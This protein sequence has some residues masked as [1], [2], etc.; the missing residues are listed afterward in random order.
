MG[1]VSVA[2]AI[3]MGSQGAISRITLS[4]RTPS[5]WYRIIERLNLGE[6]ESGD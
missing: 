5:A 3:A 4:A 6:D 2:S 1:R